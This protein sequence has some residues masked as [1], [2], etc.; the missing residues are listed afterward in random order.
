VTKHVVLL[1]VLA[2]L[3][4]CCT[5]AVATDWFVATNGNDSNAGT[6]GAPFATLSAAF[7]YNNGGV[8]TRRA[9]PGDTVYVRA[10]T[11]ATM[12]NINGDGYCS[13]HFTD[14]S[15]VGGA[16]G[17]PITVRPYDGDFTAVFTACVRLVRC[18][19]IVLNGLDMSA[20]DANPASTAHPL[21][22]TGGCDEWTDPNKRSHHIEIT[23]CKVHDPQQRGQ[24]KVQQSDYIDIHDSELYNYLGC[25]FDCVWVNNCTFHRNYV[26]NIFTGGFVKG[27]SLYNTFA[28][29][30]Y[31]DQADPGGDA[32]LSAWGFLPGNCTLQSASSPDYHHQSGY[33]VIRNNIVRGAKRG[34]TETAGCDYAYVYNNLFVDC[35]DPNISTCYS[36]V[37]ALAI[38]GNTCFDPVTYYYYVFNNMFYDTTGHM[39]PYGSTLSLGGNGNIVNWYTGNNNFY[40]NGQPLTHESD[41]PDPTTESGATY[42]DPHLTL[43]GSPTT[44]Q[45]WVDYYR[46]LWDT[47]S[48]AM[49]RDK[50]TS[51]A[52]GIPR[53]GVIRDI[54]GNAR[55]KDGGWDIGP[56]EYQGA[57]VTPVADFLGT[58]Q[59]INGSQQW[60]TPPAAFDFTDLSSG[61]PTSWSWSFGDSSSSTAQNPSHTYSSYGQYTVALT[62]TNSAGNNT[63]TKTNYIT[64]KP[65]NAAFTASPTT[66]NVTQVVNFTD[67]SSNSPTA[68]SWSFGD[69]G[70]STAQNP[71]HTYTSAAS[72]TVELTATNAD[73]SD[74]CTKTNYITISAFAADFTASPTWG[75]PPL[76]VSFTDA[77]KN[78]ATAW[79]WTFGDGGSSTEQNPSHTYTTSAYY[80]VSLQASNA[81]GSD[82]ETKSSFITVCSGS[83]YVYPTSY[84][85]PVPSGGNQH[86]VSRTLADLQSGTGDGMVFAC[87]TAVQ[88]HGYNFCDINFS[89]PTGY[90]PSQIA[91]ITLDWQGKTSAGNTDI[92][93]QL[94][95]WPTGRFPNGACRIQY[96]PDAF[97]HYAF[98][99]SKASLVT[100]NLLDSSGNVSMN[101]CHFPYVDKLATYTISVNWVRWTVFLNPTG[102][103]APVA[104]FSG[105]PTSG[106]APLAVNFTDASTNSPTS[107]SWDFGDSSTSTVQNSSHTYNSA[108]NYTVSLTASNAGGSDGETKTDYITVTVPAPVADFTADQTVGLAGVGVSFT[109]TSTNTPTSWSWTFGDSGTSTAQNPSHTYNS[110]GYY[111]VALT[112]TNAGGNDTETKTNYIAVCTEVTLYPNSFWMQD[113]RGATI[114]S[115]TLAD[116]RS[117]NQIYHVSAPNQ[118][119]QDA[120]RYYFDVS[121]AASDLAQLS[122][123]SQF[124][125]SRADVPLHS[126]EMRH[127]DNNTWELIIPQ[128]LWGTE[129]RDTPSFVRSAVGEYLLADGQIWVDICGC[130]GGNYNPYQTSVDF[131]RL[132]LWVKPGTTISAPTAD[133]SGTPTTG[134][135]PLS[136]TFTDASTGTP[137]FWAWD[138]G[139][140]TSSTVQSPSH[141]YSNTGTYS[142]A[143]TVNNGYGS[144][145]L[146]RSD[147][148]TV[149]ALPPAPV[150]DFSGTPTTGTAPLAVSFTDSST[151]TPTAWSWDFGDSNTSTV[152][153]PSHTYAAGTYTVSLTATNAGG[154]DGETKTN[155]I[156]ATVAA[157]T[158]VA[159]GS[160]ASGTGAIT[161]ALP[162]G[163]QTNDI[164]LLFLETAN[165]AISISNQNGGTWTQV[166]NSPQGYGTAGATNATR[167]TVYWSRYNG[168]QGAPTT[169]DSGNHQLGRIIAIRG[170]TTSGDPCNITA[171][172]TESTVDTSGAIPGATTTVA[173]TLVVAAIA[174]SLPDTNGTANFSAWSNG[175]LSGLAERTDNTRS[176]GNG[177]GLGVATGVKAAA[178]AYTTTSVTCATAS[179]K[180]MMSIAIK[181]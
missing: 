113:W 54:E 50:G 103:P 33:T 127:L 119:N 61:G 137:T 42:G 116:I 83:V 48:N 36:Y 57:A 55:P 111:T 69:S 79:S 31:I 84:S 158:F 81:Y 90:T 94:C 104:D 171:G 52:G 139:D 146:T 12:M 16:P 47:Q 19:Y 9:Q 142:V 102:T 40:N 149:N 75:M 157:P 32:N 17:A 88:Y 176:S 162:A 10:G 105:T 161:P 72:F 131:I 59:G 121:Y 25:G 106:A 120:R 144:N 35:A 26:H 129:D 82:T 153:N 7:Y 8:L 20:V 13:V 112:A 80:T 77:S 160:V 168:T 18:K 130:N 145:S 65:L 134:Y 39:R 150:A 118:Y 156:T 122:L 38:T 107:W 2:F 63:C 179:T 174:T 93:G 45:G 60:A 141:S 140:G 128:Q 166:T 123:E 6:I 22:I 51:A 95:P 165:Q 132:K 114:V 86:V 41:T 74:T 108:G 124:K 34:A 143:L 152:Q 163:L 115:G 46:P 15:L 172:G 155:Y 87:D 56:Y 167:L 178:G 11:Y 159:A 181:P 110:V 99:Q 173:N 14:H 5:A 97:V 3:L 24:L 49:L 21:S 85:M 66:G 78:N 30:A 154:S 27:G 76:A 58:C 100:N 180:A 37:T 177:G 133:F 70:A 1:I 29:N 170:A 98:T 169:S 101:E 151:N 64:V 23:N 117:D 28:D 147:Y 43:S 164:L 91:G 44:W 73:G 89:A 126:E 109:D 67:Q 71:T 138:F 92:C 53:P 96:M 4:S 135:V 148:I 68:W 62:A 125:S 136:V 175:D